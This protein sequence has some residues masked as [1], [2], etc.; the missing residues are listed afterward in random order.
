MTKA[1]FKSAA[2]RNAY[3]TAATTLAAAKG[4]LMRCTV[5]GLRPNLAAILRSGAVR[6]RQNLSDAFFQDGGHRRGLLA[7]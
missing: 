7:K 3:G 4:R 6:S 1:D 2:V 5:P